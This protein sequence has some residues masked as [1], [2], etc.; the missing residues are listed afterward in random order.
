MTSTFNDFLLTVKRYPFD[1][2]TLSETWLKDNTQLLK[3]VSIPGYNLE[4]R[5]REGIKGGGVGAYIKESVKYKR[6]KDIEKVK[7]ELENRIYG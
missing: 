4:Y 6:P 5:N 3:Y 2:L 7:P 1:V